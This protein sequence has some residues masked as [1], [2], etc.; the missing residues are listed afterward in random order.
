MDDRF[1]VYILASRTRTL[2]IGV[3][4]DLERRLAQHRTG[5]G[6]RFARRY[7]VDRLVLV[8][9]SPDPLSAITREKQLKGWIRAE[10]IALIESVNPGWRDLAADPADPSAP[11]G[12]SG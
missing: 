2:Y 11:E 10:K 12:A 9:W 5:L 4:N 8:E 3:T 7:S 1:V 6:S